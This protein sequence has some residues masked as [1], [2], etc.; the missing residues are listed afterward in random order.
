[1]VWQLHEE[2]RRREREVEVVGGGSGGRGG[3]SA[4]FG[5]GESL[6]LV[7]SDSAPLLT[8]LGRDD[9]ADASSLGAFRSPAAHATQALPTTRWFDGHCVAAQLVS[10]PATESPPPLVSPASSSGALHQSSWK[11]AQNSPTPSRRA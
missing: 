10:P 5:G 2:Q 11:S 9:S 8:F 6:R 7:P 1:M 4:E 3:A